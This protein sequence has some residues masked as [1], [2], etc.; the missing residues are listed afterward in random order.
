MKKT[1]PR[2]IIIKLLSNNGKEKNLQSSLRK[3]TYHIQEKKNKN[4]K[5]FFSET[6]E[7]KRQWMNSIFKILGEKKTLNLEFNN[8]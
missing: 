7:A 1:T 8:H 6:M 2:H 4:D 5:D 3:K